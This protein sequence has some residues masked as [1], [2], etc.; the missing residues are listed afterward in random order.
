MK[1]KIEI[2]INLDY[3]Y[4]KDIM[5][6]YVLNIDMVIKNIFKMYITSIFIDKL[7]AFYIFLK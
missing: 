5:H 3:I 2:Y 6:M 1:K 4:K 7:F